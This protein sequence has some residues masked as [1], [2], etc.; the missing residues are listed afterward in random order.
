MVL[1][2]Y[3]QLPNSAS[4]L[5]KNHAVSVASHVK[6]IAPFEAA[7]RDMPDIEDQI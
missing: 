4:V 3:A 5:S 2:C 7:K 6:C 1:I